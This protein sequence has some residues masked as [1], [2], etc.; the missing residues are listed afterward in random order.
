METEKV[1]TEMPRPMEEDQ[2]TRVRMVM[3]G[4]GWNVSTVAHVSGA[5]VRPRHSSSI[6]GELIFQRCGRYYTSLET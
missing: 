5:A 1:P 2:V 4:V 6:M 3:V